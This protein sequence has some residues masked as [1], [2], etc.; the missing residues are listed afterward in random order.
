MLL[1]SLLVIVKG[2]KSSSPQ[3]PLKLRPLAASLHGQQAFFA[4][5]L[6]QA[7]RPQLRLLLPFLGS[8]LLLFPPPC[9]VHALLVS[10]C[11]VLVLR[12]GTDR[13]G[14]Q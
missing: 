5:D 11:T 14:P 8:Q 7:S 3:Q 4:A 2:K 12:R 1:A 13:V 10:A 6:L 9:S